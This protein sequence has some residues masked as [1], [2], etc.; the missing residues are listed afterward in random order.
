M[1][2]NKE[3]VVEG[4]VW[5]VGNNVNTESI[6]P[7]RWL[8]EG[9]DL[10][11]KHIGEILIPE[12]PEKV[13]GG[14]IWAGGSNL[15]C[16]SS[17]NAPLFLKEK[18]IGVI[19]CHS[20]SRIFYRNALNSGLPIFEMG[21]DIEKIKTGHR[22]KVNVRRGEIKNLTTGE[23]IMTKPFPDF[24]MAILEAGGINQ[25]ILSRKSEYKLLK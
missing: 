10:L 13:K 7:S 17:R 22:V 4:T 18:G 19:L 6:T 8:H 12:F 14:D 2:S 15:G 25:Y 11:M 20:A 5:K 9:R 3:W 23:E 1:Q 16:S 21:E 24:M